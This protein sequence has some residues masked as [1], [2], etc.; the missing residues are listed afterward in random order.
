MQAGISLAQRNEIHK[1]LV[2]SPRG[3][4][5]EALKRQLIVAARRANVAA[6]QDV[7]KAY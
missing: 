7:S 6:G 1:L 2:A 4:D 3:T 5:H